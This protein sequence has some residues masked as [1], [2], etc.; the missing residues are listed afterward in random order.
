MMRYVTLVLVLWL[1]ACGSSTTVVEGGE[2]SPVGA[3]NETGG[4][5]SG[6]AVLAAGA[7]GGPGGA[8]SA[9]TGGGPPLASGGS[10]LATGGVSA[11]GAGSGATPSTG[12]A[13]P[14]WSRVFVTDAIFGVDEFDGPLTAD[15]LCQQAA[16]SAGLGST[17]RAYLSKGTTNAPDR[18]VDVSPWHRMDGE[19]AFATHEQLSLWPDVP[20]NMTEFGVPLATNQLAWTGTFKGVTRYDCDGW[21]AS[22]EVQRQADLFSTADWDYRAAGGYQRLCNPALEQ[23]HLFCFEQ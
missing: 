22:A 10:P 23:H 3:Q 15:L 4:W 7:G 1:V 5:S 16:E 13:P 20:I 8:L 19:L 17:W 6:G 9:F 14:A 21:E 12:G 11:A 2:N 18:L